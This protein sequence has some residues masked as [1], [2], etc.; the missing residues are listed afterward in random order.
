MHFQ[1]KLQ[2]IN[3]HV[4]KID[5][6]N[7]NLEKSLKF[8][9]LEADLVK[10]H[11][12]NLYDLY[13]ELGLAKVAPNEQLVEENVESPLNVS[14][15]SNAQQESVQE[16][17]QTI[18]KEESIKT[19]AEPVAPI[20]EPI[21]QESIKIEPQK[22]IEDV[23]LASA[24][25]QVQEHPKVEV[26][27]PSKPE[28]IEQPKIEAPIQPEVIV[29]EQSKVDVKPNPAANGN[30]TPVSLFEKYQ[31]NHSSKEDI[32]KVSNASKPL[33]QLIS[34][35]DK[36]IIIKELFGN[37]VTKYDAMIAKV[38]AMSSKQEAMQ[39]FSNEIWNVPMLSENEEIKA[40]VEAILDLKFVD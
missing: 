24:T 22:I 12:R 34:L 23:K 37:S 15:A 13:N 36:F 2:Q 6:I 29:Q 26:A 8:S 5:T 28:N 10:E 27:M 19:T 39:Y 31:D 7:K 17:A 30:G 1:D 4:G 3:Q 35:N 21:V 32:N 11:L 38:D 20:D 33:K 40:R 25:E 18:T 16:V 14:P 9:T